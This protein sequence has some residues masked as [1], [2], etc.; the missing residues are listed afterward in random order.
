MSLKLILYFIRTPPFTAFTP[1]YVGDAAHTWCDIS[2]QRG[3]GRRLRTLPL[4]VTKYGPLS[5]DCRM[6]CIRTVARS[7]WTDRRTG[8]IIQIASRDM[9]PGVPVPL[10]MVNAVASHCFF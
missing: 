2:M 5:G 8:T 6:R 7:S 9:G 1:T 4:V 10:G 3:V